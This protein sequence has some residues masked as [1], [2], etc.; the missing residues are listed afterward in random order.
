MTMPIDFTYK[1]VASW[2]NAKTYERTFMI[3]LFLRNSIRKIARFFTWILE[4]ATSNR[5]TVLLLTAASRFVAGSHCTQCTNRSDSTFDNSS[6]DRLSSQM[7]HRKTPNEGFGF[8]TENPFFTWIFREI[9]KKVCELWKIPPCVIFH[10]SRQALSWKEPTISRRRRNER[11]I[12]RATGDGPDF[13]GW[14]SERQGGYSRVISFNCQS[15][16]LNSFDSINFQLIKFANK[17][18]AFRRF[19]Q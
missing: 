11:S 6:S 18:T 10:S 16:E 8:R 15:T 13:S 7:F 1:P 2:H 5:L 12:C 14:M 17:K 19:F 9:N 4:L 3:Y